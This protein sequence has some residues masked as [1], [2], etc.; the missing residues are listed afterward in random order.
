MQINIAWLSHLL[1]TKFLAV[2]VFLHARHVSL[3]LMPKSAAPWVASW[4]DH[5]RLYVTPPNMNDDWFW[6]HAALIKD[7]LVVSN[8]ELRDHHFQM[9]APRG[10]VRWKDRHRVRFRFGL[11]EGDGGG[12]DKVVAPDH[13]NN[14]SS[15]RRAVHLTF[16]DPFSRRIQR[17]GDGLVVPLPR[18][19]D[20]HRFLEGRHQA[21]DTATPNDESY[22][23]LRPLR[24]STNE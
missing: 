21:D 12:D 22:L 23:C 8:D 9:L 20:E 24:P 13:D 11:W 17:V 5:D 3:P 1:L 14:Q 2:L 6:L 16:P 18:R 19:G 4:R 10:F 7:S 15:R